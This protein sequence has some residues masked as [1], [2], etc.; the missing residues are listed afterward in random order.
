VYEEAEKEE[1]HII[2]TGDSVKVKQ[3]LDDA[4]VEAVTEAGYKINYHSENLKL[5]FMFL[6]CVS[7]MVAQFYP[8]P[9]PQSRPLLG[10]CCAIYF[11][12]STVLQYIVSFVDRDTIIITKPDKVLTSKSYILISLF[13][14]GYNT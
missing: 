2:E 6:S 9:F 3:V 4:T 14:I 10:L 5:L 8:L 11:I 7:A 13:N 1:H 12:L